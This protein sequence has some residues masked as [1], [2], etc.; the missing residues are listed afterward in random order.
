MST[1]RV[2]LFGASGFLGRHAMAALRADVRTD[3]VIR[4]GRERPGEDG[5]VSHDLVSGSSE[6]LARLLRS[7]RPDVVVNCAG[8]L[9]GTAAELVAANVEGN[10][11]LVD[12][13]T[14]VLPSTRLVALGS[15][16]EYGVVPE[17][18]PVT[19]E[20]PAN[21]VSVY[22]ISRLAG[23]QL[24]RL[25]A[26]DGKL[27]GVVLRVFN[28]IGPGLHG[29]NLLG[30]AAA[31][32]RTALARGEDLVRLGPLGAYRDF[33]DVRDVATAISA[34]ALADEVSEPV[35]NVGS[36]KAVTCR[37]A[38][39][40]L[41]EAAGFTGEIVESDPPPARS[42]AVGWIVADLTRTSR[43][44]DWAPSVDLRDSVRAVWTG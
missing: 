18:Q 5:W 43:V 13:I 16:A 12:V 27:D 4:V 42:A 36:G 11:R 40:L 28:P 10:A 41:A 44:L 21:P 22:G 29:E 6:E 30:R 1:A 3:E 19:E 26:T 31:D 14:D 24:V 37:D 32:I 8:R 35:L 20:A 38:V 34:A 2:L 9:A 15:A 33:V 17:D 25:A 39:A 7:I 23:T